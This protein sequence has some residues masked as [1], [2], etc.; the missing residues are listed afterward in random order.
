MEPADMSRVSSATRPSA[1]MA[2]APAPDIVLA[3][4]PG[5]PRK[6]ALPA[7]PRLSPLMQEVTTGYGKPVYDRL[8]QKTSRAP[9][10][11]YVLARLMELCTEV[12]GTPQP[13]RASNSEEARRN[14]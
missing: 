10:E 12:A 2:R 1:Q 3:I 14:F 6:T 11:N 9:E 7:T 8:A 13:R 5:L 4:K